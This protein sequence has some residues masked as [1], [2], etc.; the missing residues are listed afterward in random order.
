MGQA[1]PEK[2]SSLWG[3]GSCVAGLV[4]SSIAGSLHGYVMRATIPVE[5]AGDYP[6]N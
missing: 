4:L 3:S 1:G 6:E 2:G 5:L